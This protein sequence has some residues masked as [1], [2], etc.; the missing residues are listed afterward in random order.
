MNCFLT[1]EQM[2]ETNLPDFVS[3]IAQSRGKKEDLAIRYEH[4][5]RRRGDCS[6]LLLYLPDDLL[7]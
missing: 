6:K 2:A 3:E 1:E 4:I 5:D 7:T